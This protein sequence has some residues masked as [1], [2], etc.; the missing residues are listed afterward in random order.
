[1]F[2][3]ISPKQESLQETLHSLRFASKVNACQIG[4]ARKKVSSA[5]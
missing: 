1:M 2:V 5:K 4:T 3:N